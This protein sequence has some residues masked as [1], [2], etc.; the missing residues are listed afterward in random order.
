VNDPVLLVCVLVLAGPLHGPSADGVSAGV[1]VEEVAE[2]SAAEKAGIQAGDEIRSW[3]LA[4]TPP[5]G[6]RLQSPF[7][8]ADVEI[9]HSPR[10]PITLLGARAGAELSWTLPPV[11]LGLTARPALAGPL[12]S[13]YEEGRSL[14]RSGQVVE[15]ADRWR[16]LAV[17]AS[18]SHQPALA[19][20]LHSGRAKVLAAARRHSEAD[21][22]Y[23]E[24][25]R[26]ADGGARSSVV[27]LLWRQWGDAFRDRGDWARADDSYRQAV[28]WNEKLGSASLGTARSLNRLGM[29]AWHRG[30][31]AAAGDY[32]RRAFKIIEAL[33]PGS[34]L[35]GESLNNLGL[36]SLERA[37]LPAAEEYHRRALAVGEAMAPESVGVGIVL[38]N[39]GEVAKARGDLRGAEQYLRRALTVMER[40]A[41]GSG[42]VAWVLN[43]L[44]SVAKEGGDLAGAEDYCRRALAMQEKAEPPESIALA[45]TL[46]NLGDVMLR[47]GDLST[48]AGHYERARAIA[49]KLA[50]GS[51]EEAEALHG[52]GQIQRRSGRIESASALFLRAL[53]ALEQ[54][55]AKLGGTQEV[56]S[57]FT[58]SYAGYYHD[59]IEMLTRLGRSAEALHTLE[60][61]RARLFLALLAERDLAFAADLPP[62][63]ARERRMINAEYDRVQAAIGGPNAG[64]GD[65]PI[66]MLRGRLGELRAAQDETSAKIR[67]ASARLASIQYPQ[68]L[69]LAG[70]RSA[71]DP[72]TLLLSYSVGVES[73][74]LF[75]VEAAAAPGSGLSVHSIPVGDKALR[76][77]VEAL[78]SAIQPKARV[79][80][81]AFAAQAAEL[82]DLL[83]RPA[84]SL[85]SASARL[86]ISPDGP[87]HSLPFGALVRKGAR[88]AEPARAYLIER[89]PLHVAASA[90]V[91]AQIRNSRREDGSPGPLVAFGDPLYPRAAR[92]RADGVVD[93]DLRSV[94]SQGFRLTPLPSSRDE[95][96]AITRIFSGRAQKYLGAEATE[97]RAKSLGRDARYVHFACHGSLDERFPL[98]SALALAIPDKP[99]E[100]L[101]NGL[102]QAWEIF[103][104]VRID[105]DLVTL[106]ACDTALGKEMGG[107]G[108]LGLTRAFQYAGARSVLAS[109]WAVSDRSTPL[110][111][112][113]FYGHLSAGRSAAEALRAA[114]IDL[115]RA[116]GKGPE[117]TRLSHPF[118]WAAFQLYGDWQ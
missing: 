92:G 50:P 79:R 25:I 51:A 28:T 58:A 67:T 42:N 35:Y 1:V 37:D 63:L 18:D 103:E 32:G 59:S 82:Y 24:A 16:A 38:L 93:P 68:P 76:R 73:T 3:S 55:G 102:L 40:S 14:I 30:D 110:L 86:L 107:E 45:V 118:R 98:N 78:R 39:L 65:A 101:D 2:E 57:G 99:A 111:M 29:M 10:G 62:E 54:Q 46:R 44:G 113:R 96:E 61:S 115:I 9:E 56:R 91:Y 43:S 47:R 106:S 49:E 71:L 41:A 31:F 52:L 48:A 36:L 20:W 6:G 21:A 23:E 100:G 84:E 19:A 15:G 11:P 26:E 88:P 17:A 64:P 13:S 5:A 66:E 89:K 53:D 60:R 80:T 33:A 112:K 12:L 108:L 74:V 72:G 95:V 83:V 81:E 8:L 69:E 114:Q 104:R 94:L 4:A 90:T 70:I 116:P 109:L 27:A 117:A 87:L 34:V 22:A 77:K 97:E 7:D 105:A 85:V 75:A